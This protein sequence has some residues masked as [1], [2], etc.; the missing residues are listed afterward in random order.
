VHGPQTHLSC[1]GSLSHAD[2]AQ[3]ARFVDAPARLQQRDKS[4]ALGDIFQDLATPRIDV[5]GNIGMT[6]FSFEDPGHHH[7]ISK[8]RIDAAAH[9]YLVHLDPCRFTHGNHVAR[10]RRAGNEGFHP[11]QVDLR[12]F[13]VW[14][15]SS[16]YNSCQ[17]F[18]RPWASR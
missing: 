10:R 9:D 14:A 1:A 17:T 11:G 7:Q 3:T 18:P 13:V 2:A 15:P 5:E 4:P 16:A 12:M 6:V 8:R